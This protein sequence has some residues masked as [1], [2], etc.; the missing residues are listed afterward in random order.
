MKKELTLIAL[1]LMTLLHITAQQTTYSKVYYNLSESAHANDLVRASNNS[2]FVVGKYNMNGLLMNSD[3]AGNTIMSKQYEIGNGAIFNSI[4]IAP[5]SNLVIAGVAGDGNALLMKVDKNGDTLW[6][7]MLDFGNYSESYGVCSLIDSGF[8]FCGYAYGASTDT[9]MFVARTDKN[10]NLI[11]SKTYAGGNSSN[12]A[13]SVKQS[14][15]S[16]IVVAGYFS[17]FPPYESSAVLLKLD[18]NGDTMWTK[19]YFGSATQV[20][21]MADVVCLGNGYVFCGEFGNQLGMAK[22]DTAGN[23]KWFKKYD[24][25]LSTSLNTIHSRLMS[26]SDNRFLIA[27]V[28]EMFS[29]GKIIVTDSSGMPLISR[30]IVMLLTSAVETADSGFMIAG[31]GPIY[32]VKSG[33][34]FL[35]NNHFSLMKTDSTGYSADCNNTGGFLTTFLMLNSINLHPVLSSLGSFV[36][37]HPIISNVVLNSANDC[38]TI[39]GGFEE[40]PDNTFSIFPNPSSGQ[41]TIQFNQ[42]QSNEKC[43]IEVYSTLGACIYSASQTMNNEISVEL[44]NIKPGLYFLIV[45]TSTERTTKMFEIQ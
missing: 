23:V 40:T 10:G 45:G 11:W 34:R 7:R 9:K 22:V 29:F 26:V 25:S 39:L 15:D 41:F 14:A 31:N 6:T 44:D 12:Y 27:V 8:A 5:D 38:V 19:G 21:S 33:Q 1:V 17:D 2:Y 16:G 18:T 35:T 3:S 37:I 43:I 13:Y 20:N 32:G 30:D 24:S 36:N 28:S 4:I 42:P